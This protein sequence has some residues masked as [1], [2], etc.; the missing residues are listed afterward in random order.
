[1]GMN[2]LQLFCYLEPFCILSQVELV[3]QLPT[4]NT[5]LPVVHLRKCK[6]RKTFDDPSGKNKIGQF[7]KLLS[8]LD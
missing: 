8:T 4:G 1:M 3:I 6:V 5:I 7:L 2:T